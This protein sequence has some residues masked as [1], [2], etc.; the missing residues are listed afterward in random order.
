MKFYLEK[1]SALKGRVEI[2]GQIGRCNEY[3]FQVFNLLKDN[4]LHS[5][6]HLFYRVRDI[7]RTLVDFS[8]SWTAIKRKQ[9]FYAFLDLQGAAEEYPYHPLDS[10]D[11]LIV[12]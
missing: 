11:L 7:L 1:K 5:I 6:V 4:V 3:S 8:C 12:F 10:S 9:N 2:R